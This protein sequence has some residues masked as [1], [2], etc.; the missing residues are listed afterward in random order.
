M[1]GAGSGLTRAAAAML[2]DSTRP[3]NLLGEKLQL[4]RGNGA[5]TRCARPENKTPALSDRRSVFWNVLLARADRDAEAVLRL[6]VLDKRLAHAE[7]HA[8]A[9]GQAK[10]QTGANHE[11]RAALRLAHGAETAVAEARRHERRDLDVTAKGELDRQ[12]SGDNHRLHILGKAEAKLGLEAHRPT[13]GR[14]QRRAR[15]L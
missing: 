8:D 11:A 13:R 12:T 5:R 15:E 9:I 4:R 2:A 10:A 7:V 14:V 1:L 3:G 6:A